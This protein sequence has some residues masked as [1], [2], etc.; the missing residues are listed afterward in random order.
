MTCQKKSR[1]SF[2]KKPPIGVIRTLLCGGIILQQPLREGGVVVPVR[3]VARALGRF[4]GQPV[5]REWENPG[6]VTIR[7]LWSR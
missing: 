3:H 7:L 1:W 4:R 6:M 5:S 2:H